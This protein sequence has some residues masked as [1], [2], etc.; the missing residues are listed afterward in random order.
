MGNLEKGGTWMEHLP[1]IIIFGL[2]LPAPAGSSLFSAGK[3]GTSV[4]CVMPC[5]RDKEM[6][7]LRNAWDAE[8]ISVPDSLKTETQKVYRSVN[9]L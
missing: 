8:E 2:K 9:H 7:H 6:G 4:L 3:L 5:N 1:N